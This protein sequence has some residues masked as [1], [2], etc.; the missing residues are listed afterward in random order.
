MADRKSEAQ[1]RPHPFCR[2]RYLPGKS[3]RSHGKQ[4]TKSIS[5]TFSACFRSS[6]LLLPYLCGEGAA[7]ERNKGVIEASEFLGWGRGQTDTGKEA[8]HQ[9]EKEMF[10][11]V[12]LKLAKMKTPSLS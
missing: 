11:T 2:V 5:P 9:S 1:S 8:K 7:D 10:R 6:R 12:S 4:E 3:I